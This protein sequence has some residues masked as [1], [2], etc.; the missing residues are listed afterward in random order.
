MAQ[1]TAD[2]VRAELRAWL[3]EAWDP[4]LTVARVVGAARRRRAG[5]C[6]TWPEEW[7][8]T[9]PRPATRS[10]V[11]NDELRDGR[12]ARAA[13]GPRRCCSPGPTIL[14]HGTDEQKERYLRPIVTGR[15]AG[16]SSS[17]SR[18][19]A[20]TSRACRP[21]PSATATSG[22]I[23]GQKVWTSGGQIAELGMLL[24]RTDPDAAEAHRASPTSR[25]RW[26]SR[27]SRCDRCAR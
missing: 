27:A 1:P 17:A 19:P 26:T 11:V 21:R 7:L 3:D 5:R 13:V 2:E 12:R 22:S 16:A 8:G 6:P 23:N 14:T 15:R 9:R 24:A 10:R 4:D 20:P 25:S 18:A